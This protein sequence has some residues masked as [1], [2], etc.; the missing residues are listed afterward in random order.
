MQSCTNR[1]TSASGKTL[2][3]PVECQRHT[4]GRA[5][6]QAG[7]MCGRRAP[8]M[9]RRYDR[10]ASQTSRAAIL[11]IGGRG[12]VATAVSWYRSPAGYTTPTCGTSEI[13]GARVSARRRRYRR[14][15]ALQRGSCIGL[16]RYRSGAR[17]SR[18]C[19]IGLVLGCWPTRMRPSPRSRPSSRCPQGPSGPKP[20][21]RTGG[22]RI[23]FVRCGVPPLSCGRTRRQRARSAQAGHR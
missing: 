10:P 21:A 8:R 1:P 6:G 23:G 15:P 16:K 19:P 12:I 20:R 2:R 22:R 3:G 9:R 4:A 17:L 7:A 5:R 14:L 18:V 13:L 11:S